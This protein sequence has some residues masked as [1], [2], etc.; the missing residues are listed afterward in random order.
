MLNVFI[1]GCLATLLKI[2]ERGFVGYDEFYD[3]LGS[4]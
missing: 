2:D 3:F 1:V 4:C